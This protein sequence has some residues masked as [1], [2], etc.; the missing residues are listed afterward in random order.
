MNKIFKYELVIFIPC[1]GKDGN[2]LQIHQY[3]S[4]VV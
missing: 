2:G 3:G 1:F 4:N